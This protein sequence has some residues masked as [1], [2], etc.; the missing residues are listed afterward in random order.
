MNQI[1]FPGLGLQFNIS[2]IAFT[3][4]GVDIAWY[5]V[6]IVLAIIIAL[7]IYKKR[8]G[9]Y[10][11]SFET[12]LELCLYVIPISFICARAYYVVFRLDYFL[13]D[14]SQILNIKQGGLAIYGGIIGGTV[15]CY[16]FAKKKKIDFSNLLDFIV[17]ALPLRASNRQMGKLHKCR[18]IWNRN[19]KLFK[20]G[21]F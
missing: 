15:T 20:N 21:H 9:L 1:T 13:Q 7:A 12:V 14:P 5:A 10:G 4:F 16:I 8:D 3:I 2:K 18:S 6:L 19:Y 11:I 17:P